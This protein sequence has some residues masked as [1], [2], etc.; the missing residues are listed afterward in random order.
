LFFLLEVFPML[1]IRRHVATLFTLASCVAMT[2]LSGPAGAQPSVGSPGRTCDPEASRR[3]AAAYELAWEAPGVWGGLNPAQHLKLVV[4]EE[5]VTVQ[6]PTGTEE[7]PWAWGLSLLRRGNAETLQSEA[8]STPVVSSGHRIDLPHSF[9]AEWFF[10]SRKGLQHG[11]DL[12]AGARAPG[13]EIFEFAVRGTLTPKVREDGRAILFVDAA[14]TPI[15]SYDD[16]HAMDAAG[17]DVDLRWE[18]PVTG[19]T[20][21]VTIRLVVEGTGHAL[22]I[23]IRG[24]VARGKAAPAAPVTSPIEGAATGMSPSSPILQVAPTNDLCPGAEVIPGAGPFPYTSGTYD[25]TDATTTNDPPAN[26]CQPDV[27]RSIWFAFTPTTTGF[28]SFSLCS[29][30]PTLTTVVDTVLAVYSATAA[31]SG[32]SAVAGGCDDDSCSVTELQSVVSGLQ[33]S[34]GQ[35][36]YI[37]AWQ[38]GSTAPDP[39]AAAIQLRVTQDSPPPAAPPNDQCAGAEVIPA[40]GPFPYLTSLIA[41]I[42]SATLTGDPPAPSCQPTVSRSVWYSFTPAATA[43]YTFSL[44]AD[45]QTGTTVDDTVL[46][47]YTGTGICS[48]LAEMPSACADDSCVVELG[49]SAITGAS[50]SA[51]TTYY[52]VA[53]KFDLPPPTTGNTA[54]QMRVT[55][56]QGPPNDTCSGAVPLTLNTPVVGTTASAADNYELSGS[57]CFTGVGQTPT[58]AS[59]S[60]VVYRF[61]A[62]AAGSYSFRVNGFDP[63]RNAVVYVSTDCPGGPFP[64]IIGGCL[65]AANRNSGSPAEE[66]K[67]LALAASQT[68]NVFV[69]EVSA[70]LGSAFNLEVT[71]C[72]NEVEP[73]GT[74]ATAGPLTCGVEGS[75][76]PTGDADFFSIGTPDVSARLFAIVDGVATN[77]TDLDMRVTTTVDTLEY[78]DANN[79]TPYGSL[80]PNLAGSPL[81]G[82][83]SYVEINHFS[84]TQQSEP[85]RLYTVIEPASAGATAEIEPNNSTASATTGANLYF[86]GALSSASDVDIFGFTAAAGDLIQV[87]LDLDPTRNNTPFNGILALLDASGATLVSVNDSGATSSTTPGTGSLIAKTP[88]SPAEGLVWRARTGGTYY[89]KVSYSAGTAGDY[90][91]AIALNCRVG[92]PTDLRVTQTDAPDPVTPGANVTYTVTVSN[93]GPA[94]ATF[95]SLRDDPPA[96]TVFVSAT[97]SQGACTGTAPVTC[98]LGTIANGASATV[99]IVVTAP[100]SPGTI[101]NSAAVTSMVIDAN[102]AND[103]AQA[104]TTVGLPDSD[105]DGVP[106]ATDCA[107]SDPTAWAIPSEAL[108]LR[109]PTIANLTQMQWDA[110]ASPGGTV[111]SYDLLRSAVKGDFSAAT[112]V[113]TGQTGLTAADATTPTQIFYYLVRS[114]NVC[115][116]NLGVASNGTPRT[117]ISCP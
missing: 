43:S 23:Q 6:Q 1:T 68:V 39:T 56:L 26:A 97:P 42:S 24:L 103:A 105:G 73:N 5:G 69:D 106:D 79:D 46:A 51:G 104:T 83:A 90:L 108:N 107:P 84:A 71:T 91:V 100:G 85:Y 25:I 40:A 55:E 96:G 14:G 30:A 18:R 60:D 36:Y 74:P 102:P 58:P 48:G 7:R 28:Y 113:V 64:A 110:P 20:C 65:G 49:Q 31:C 88:N 80:S 41:D 29:D 16:L 44:C 32:L 9:G 61:T 57:A 37:V 116:G 15:L 114:R 117:G 77:N 86:S 19:S 92:P 112:C 89:A 72:V 13:R 54:V 35:I 4:S 47:I 78:D 50:L 81:T 67:C 17:R 38:F 94:T 95:V 76:A 2:C 3:D 12:P 8:S 10:N 63:T 59:G 109:F 22:P 45:A 115:G 99:Q 53:W 27:S 62:P 52:I 93:L 87:S 98:A 11:L 66:V 82:V 34:A 33:L 70:S 101:T 21:G 111:V 75:I